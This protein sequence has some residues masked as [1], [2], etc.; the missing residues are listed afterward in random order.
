M[1]FGYIIAG[2][3]LLANPIIHVIDILPDF[4]G[5]FLLAAGLA[6]MSYMNGKLTYVR[7]SFLKLGWV[8]LVRV[9]CIVF[10]P[11]TEDTALL[12]FA[13]VFGVAELIL[14]LPALHD[15][16]DGL[17]Y[18]GMQYGGESVFAKKKTGNGKSVEYGT[19]LMR[20]TGVFY[21]IRVVCTVLPELTS[22]QMFDGRGTV[23]LYAVDYRGF[24]NLF[25]IAS[26]LL[27]IIL[28]IVWIV[29]LCRYFG[30]IAGDK[31]FMANLREVYDRDIRVKTGVFTA[32]RM[33]CV[34]AL[35]IFAAALSL[36]MYIDD[37]NVFPGI[38][39]AI[40]LSIAALFLGR[41]VKA[42]YAVLPVSVLRS[43]L[44]V[45]SL[46]RQKVYF[47]DNRWGVVNDKGETAY[48]HYEEARAMYDGMMGLAVVENLLAI[49]S[50]VL[51]AYAFVKAVKKHLAESGVRDEGIRYSK[52][53][54]DGEVLRAIRGKVI[55]NGV[56][57][58]LQF[59]LAAA[60]LYIL[61]D[62][63][64]IFVVN[65][66]VTVLWVLQTLRTVSAAN[67]LLY[68]PLLD[69]EL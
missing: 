37:V 36:G 63:T 12:L 59:I 24:K 6:K 48:H 21:V 27:V 28:G 10:I 15:L 2:F 43:V 3:I 40:L 64:A 35:Y 60:Y 45:V 51:F 18:L 29:A 55:V 33:K 16:F 34:M 19:R 68:T 46:L 13:F 66:A 54:H 57:M 22:L 41:D 49:A 56:L 14:F 65:T 1:G 52:E 30:R 69:E 39:S 44:S 4:V 25:Y 50:F 62:F 23:D 58:L 38:L 31:T 32:K 5:F 11:Y 17:S 53:A 26:F 9:L 42:A 47:L 7:G 67:D 20:L 8:E 61:L